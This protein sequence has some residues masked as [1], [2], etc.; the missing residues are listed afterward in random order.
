MAAFAK[1]QNSCDLDV[2]LKNINI[3]NKAPLSP[4]KELHKV[5]PDADQ[6]EGW[7]KCTI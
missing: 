3:N 5:I 6:K 1:K 7:R 2:I 4:L